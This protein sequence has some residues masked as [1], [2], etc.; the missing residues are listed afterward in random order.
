[1]TVTVDDMVAAT[2][3]HRR[4]LLAYC[5]RMTGCLHDA[6]DLVQ[7]TALR[8]WRSADTYDPARSAPRTWLYRIATNL[9]LTALKNAERRALPADLSE[10]SR[11]T[12][13]GRLTAQPELAWLEPFPD[14]LLDGG[15]P[16]AVVTARESVRLAFIAALQH[17]P[18]LQRAVLVL[19]DVLALPAVEVATLLDTTTASVNSA[20]QRARSHLA[21]AAPI[22]DILT[23]PSDSQQRD[24]LDR[25]VT[26][27]ET[28]DI[29]ALKQILREDALLQMPPYA[30]WF[31]GRDAI[32]A[33]LSTVFARGGTFRIASGRANGCPAFGLYRRRDD[34]L[35]RPLNLHVLTLDHEA[36]VRMELFHS[37][38]LFPT[39]GMPTTLTP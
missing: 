39:F 4:E 38:Q 7:E 34:D 10:P 12:D 25:Y 6:E 29:D 23:E 28:M 21:A 5:Y 13:V 17:L 35:F 2:D 20:L 24:L 32:A 9:C 37:P 8:A 3:S 1:M 11:V 19:R 16:A 30:A 36:I 18:P 26:A 22:D 27:F 15:D 31:L 14:S 33:F